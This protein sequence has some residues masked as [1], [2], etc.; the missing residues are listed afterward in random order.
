MHQTMGYSNKA[1]KLATVIAYKTK[2]LISNM[3]NVQD[4]SSDSE[5]IVS[6]INENIQVITKNSH[7]LDDKLN[8]FKS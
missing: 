3:E 7:D 2:E 8:Q 1:A 6:T 4:L 5:Q